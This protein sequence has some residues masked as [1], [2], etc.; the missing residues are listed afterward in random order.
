MQVAFHFNVTDPLD[1][2]CRLVRKVRARHLTVMVCAEP[3]EVS[4]ID[5]RLWT[6]TP[7]AFLAHAAHGASPEVWARSAVVLCAEP[8]PGE[9]RQVFVNLRSHVPELGNRF[10]RLV[11]VVTTDEPSRA[12]AR[13]R[14]RSYVAQGL[15]PER[16]DVSVAPQN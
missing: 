16:H 6:L 3:A 10:E 15:T 11:E 1:Y 7:H 9:S 12:A 5:Q 2:V 8:P 14:W 4:D 13:Q